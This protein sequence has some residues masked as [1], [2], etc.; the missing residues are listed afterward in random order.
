MTGPPEPTMLVVFDSQQ[1]CLGHL[2]KRG[3]KGWE[4]IDSY[5]VSFG[6]FLSKAEA[7]AALT[8]GARGAVS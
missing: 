6:L 8:I 7:A 2:L 5:G 1:H 4:A 3:P